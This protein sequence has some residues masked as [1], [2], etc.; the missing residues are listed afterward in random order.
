MSDEDEAASCIAG[1]VSA[2]RSASII[3][4]LYAALDQKMQEIETRIEQAS[5]TGFD[6]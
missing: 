4:R 5:Q 2:A 6:A 1:A 3:T